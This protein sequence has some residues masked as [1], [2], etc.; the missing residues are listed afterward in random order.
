MYAHRNSHTHIAVH[1]HTL[2]VMRNE[3]GWYNNHKTW[4]CIIKFNEISIFLSHSSKSEKEQNKEIYLDEKRAGQQWTM[5]FGDWKIRGANDKDLCKPLFRWHT[6][7]IHIIDNHITKSIKV[8]Q[9][10]KRRRKKH[11]CLFAYGN[12]LKWYKILCGGDWLQ[13]CL[14]D[15]LKYRCPFL[16]FRSRQRCENKKRRKTKW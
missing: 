8:E 1:Q 2:G 7:S 14:R 13:N 15:T 9:K 5:S 16:L 3:F 11:K 10:K 4:L 6:H 12:D